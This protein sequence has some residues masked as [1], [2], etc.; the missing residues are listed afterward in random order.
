MEKANTL[1]EHFANIGERLAESLVQRNQ[2]NVCP[3]NKVTPVVM[4]IEITQD[5]GSKEILQ[6]KPN[7]ATGPVNISPKLLKLAGNSIVPSLTSIFEISAQTNTVP[8][9]WKT[10]NVTEIFKMM[11]NLKEK[12]IAPSP[13]FTCIPGKIMETCVANT[14]INHLQVHN[15]SSN[16]Q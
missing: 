8:R 13:S 5:H 7:K 9:K 11:T 16:Q 3:M 6:I 15:L 14:I 2:L 4:Y 10:A 12:I 1:N